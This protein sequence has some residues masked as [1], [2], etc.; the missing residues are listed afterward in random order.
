M[1]DTI[2]NKMDIIPLDIL[3]CDFLTKIRFRQICKYLYNKLHV[4]D[5]YNIET[6]Y[7]KKLTEDIFKYKI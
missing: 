7:L 2:Y 4:I 6:K 3:I 5:F 1:E